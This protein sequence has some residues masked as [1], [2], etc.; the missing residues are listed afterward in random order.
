MVFNFHYPLI[1]VPRRFYENVQISIYG[2]PGAAKALSSFD[3]ALGHTSNDDGGQNDGDDD[4]YKHEGEDDIVIFVA[5]E[6]IQR[7]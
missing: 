6:N 3:K 4:D 5:V 1:G 7:V 2:Q